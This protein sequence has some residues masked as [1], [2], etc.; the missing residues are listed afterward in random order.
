M[1]FYEGL[2]CPHC[3]R[4]FHESDDVVACPECGAPHHR[5]CWG[6]AGGCACREAHGTEHQW[7]RDAA[8]SAAAKQ[9][10]SET[11]ASAAPTDSTKCPNCG[12]A[13]SPYAEMCAHCGR[14]LKAQEWA[15]A[16]QEP[17][18]PPPPPF[19]APPAGGFNEYTPFHAAV[20]PSFGGV[21]PTTEI[22]G[23]T[24]E[25]LAA[26]VRTNTNH[27]LPRFRH[28]A[29]TGSKVAWN[30]AA[31]FIP[32]IWFFYRKMPLWGAIASAFEVLFVTVLSLLVPLFETAISE[33][34]L[35][36]DYEAF[37][38]LIASDE[39]AR[40]GSMLLTMLFV[41]FVLYHVLC[42]LFGTYL[43]MGD[44]LKKIRRTRELYPE[45]YRAQLSMIGGTSF[46]LAIIGFMCREFLPSMLLMLFLQ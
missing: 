37:Y 3:H 2:S 43:Y 22:E 14:P 33:N 8:K 6:D 36:I 30:I 39:R 16:K 34:S 10:A 19:G 23:E 18:A 12:T 46:G 27:Y 25:D 5:G 28:I 26:V 24:A 29:T 21:D 42:G 1:F 7:S 41:A 35:T 11:A 13:N 9:A 44:C 45:G 40:L 20:T 15:S 31:F 4:Q 17:T 32:H 38:A